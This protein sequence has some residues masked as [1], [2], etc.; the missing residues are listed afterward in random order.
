M[1][2]SPPEPVTPPKRLAAMGAATTA[3]MMPVTAP[4]TT[5]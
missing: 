4:A 2:K 3:A 5:M 1:T